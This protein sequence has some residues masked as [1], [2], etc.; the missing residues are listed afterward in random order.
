[1]SVDY[2]PEGDFWRVTLEGP[3]CFMT[4]WDV[5]QVILQHPRFHP[6]ASVLWDLRS[7]DTG[8]VDRT[9]MNRLVRWV[10]G[11]VDLRR[12]ARVAFVTSRD[13]DFGVARMYEMRVSSLPMEVCVF[14]AM[15]DAERWMRDGLV[16]R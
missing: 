8:R 13:V 11:E 10:E 6:G 7:A 14:R 1:M 16:A 3:L 9:A 12:G 2:E 5:W 15:P 4:F